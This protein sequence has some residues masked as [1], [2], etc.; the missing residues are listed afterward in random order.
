M[1][2]ESLP[3]ARFAGF[4][5]DELAGLHFAPRITRSPMSAHLNKEVED[6][7]RAR[8]DRQEATAV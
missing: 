8:L 1:P 3:A 7:R 2:S 6:E 4:T 5:D